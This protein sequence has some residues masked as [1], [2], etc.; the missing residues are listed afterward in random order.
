MKNAILITSISNFG[1]QTF[2]HTQETGLAKAL[3]K[4]EHTVTIYKLSKQHQKTVF[5][6]YL[7]SIP[8]IL[9]K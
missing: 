3:A 5:C 9:K 1:N 8:Q 7:Q 6:I 4:F 2:Y